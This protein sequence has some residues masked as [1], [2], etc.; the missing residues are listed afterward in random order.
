MHALEQRP[1]PP[2][3]ALALGLLAATLVTALPA[4]TAAAQDDD[5]AWYDTKILRGI[6]RGL[7][8]RGGTDPQIEYRERPPLVVPPSRDLPPPQAS[9]PPPNPAWP[10]DPDVRK[11]R[12]QAKRAKTR[13]APSAEEEAMVLTPSQM[14]PGRTPPRPGATTQ[15]QNPNPSAEQAA[16]PMTP[17][18]LGAPTNLWSRMWSAVRPAQDEV[19]TFTNEPPRA[20]LTAPPPGYQTPSPAQPYGVSKRT[21]PAKAEVPDPAREAR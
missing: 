14:T 15:S 12:D 21:E 18:Q 1:K 3:R 9:A 17:S 20:V 16:A 4:G 5:G 11:Q 6:I 19:G 10:N 2:L 13:R 8:L 7:G